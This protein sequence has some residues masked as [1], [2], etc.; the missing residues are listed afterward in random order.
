MP[1]E[2]YVAVKVRPPKSAKFKDI[3]PSIEGVKEVMLVSGHFDFL[4]RVISEN[5]FEL[6]KVLEEIRADEDVLETQ[7]SIVMERLK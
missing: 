3:F 6:S 1:V 7:T 5:T 2:A 4:L